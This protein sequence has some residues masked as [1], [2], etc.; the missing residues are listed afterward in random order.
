MTPFIF[1]DETLKFL[2]CPFVWYKVPIFWLPYF[3]LR[4]AGRAGLLPPD[5]AYRGADGFFLGDA[6]LMFQASAP[7]QAVY[8]VS[9]SGNVWYHCS[10]PAFAV[11]ETGG[12]WTSVTDFV[13]TGTSFCGDGQAKT[14]FTRATRTLAA[15]HAE[16]VLDFSGVL[17]FPSAPIVSAS[18]ASYGRA[19]AMVLNVSQAQVTV[20]STEECALEVTADQSA[21]STTSK[22]G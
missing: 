20:A 17:L 22:Q 4:S 3:W 15:S 7:G 9:L 10:N 14:G 11:N 5:V 18:V 19:S 21:Y 16:D 2:L 12:S 6:Q 13:M 8:G 1:P